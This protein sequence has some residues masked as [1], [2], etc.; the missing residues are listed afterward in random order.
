MK[1]G[2]IYTFSM[3]LCMQ[4]GAQTNITPDVLT[5]LKGSYTGTPTEKALRNAI[6]NVGIQKMAVN[7][8]NAGAKDKHFSIEVKNTGIVTG[9]EIAQIY[10]SPTS[11]DQS[12]RPIQ[13]QGFARV[14]LQPGESKTVTVKMF[15]DQF[16]FYSNEGQRKWNVMP[17]QYLIKVGSSSVDIKLQET[18][19]LKGVPVHK[20]LRDNYFSAISQS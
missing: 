1:R 4:V 7:Q 16:G 6:S 11:A 2:L 15:T 5:Q 10:L 17:G 14:S 12:I 13:L 19:T 3:M 18:V 20:P 9:D 8:E